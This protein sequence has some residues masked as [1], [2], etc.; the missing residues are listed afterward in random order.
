MNLTGEKRKTGI[1][2]HAIIINKN[3]KIRKILYLIIY[4]LRFDDD[5]VNFI[6]TH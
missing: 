6:S 1:L 3:N 4:R 2:F 5:K